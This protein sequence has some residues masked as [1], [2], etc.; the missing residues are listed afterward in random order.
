MCRV[1]VFALPNPI[2]PR[3]FNE[4]R[5]SYF[6]RGDVVTAVV[7]GVSL[8]ADMERGYP[9]GRS[10]TWWRVVEIPGRLN[11]DAKITALL[12][13]DIGNS[14]IPYMTDLGYRT[15]KRERT[16]DL[17]WLEA[18]A[19]AELGRPLAQG[20]HITLD[21]LQDINNE[22]LDRVTIKTPMPQSGV[23]G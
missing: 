4:F 7:D 23:I 5:Q 13:R 15:W 2:Q 18:W 9:L 22:F 21:R 11:N 12:A 19:E 3:P 8:G 10:E 20:E 16:V 14:D 6:L 1:V 17:D